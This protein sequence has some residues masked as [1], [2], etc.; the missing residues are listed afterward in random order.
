VG[1]DTTAATLS[2]LFY[3]LAYHPEF[4]AKL[5]K[6]V[7]DALGT[8]RRLT[9]EDLKDMKYLQHCLNEGIPLEQ[10]S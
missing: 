9:Y 7:I 2:W 6:E 10:M 4:Y 8:D 1:R 3:E 5:R